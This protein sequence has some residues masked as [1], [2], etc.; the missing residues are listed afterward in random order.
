MK[1]MLT[2][3]YSILWQQVIGLS[4]VQGAISLCWLLY[5]LYLPELLADFGLPGLAPAILIIENVLGI[6]IEP[7]AGNFSDRQRQWMGTRF[8][9]I[10]LG[11]ILATGLFIA[12]PTFVIFGQSL[13]NSGWILP[14]LLILW[15]VSMALFRSPVIA[16][17]GQYAIETKLPQAV[18]LLIFFGGIIGAFRP[19]A[20]EFI[21]SL[22]AGVTFTIGSLV[23]LGSVAILRS[24][25]PNLS[26]TPS[27]S[28]SEK[29][30]LIS[31]LFL[32]VL[33]SIF[34]A[35]GTRL[36]LGDVF[37]KLIINI[38]FDSKLGMFIGLILLAFASIPAGLL[39]VRVGNLKA[40]ASGALATGFLVFVVSFVPPLFFFPLI[41]L[42]LFC[43]S[44][45][46]N[47]VIPIAFSLVPPHRSGLGIGVYFGG[48]SLGMVIY[49]LIVNHF[50][51]V[52]FRFGSSLGMMC[53]VLVGGLIVGI[54]KWISEPSR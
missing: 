36:F 39:A 14:I 38:G 52:P 41:L 18:S 1:V 2:R 33:L 50:G 35:W 13:R 15:S 27:S 8:P 6:V 5:R 28:L 9:L 7:V 42:L 17:L 11:V 16:L 46:V 47:G 40:T 43:Y 30:G 54:G 26:V 25:N 34:V 49:D 21:L 19:I 10:S 32:I 37:P 3:Q 29:K 4:F 45:V 53:F 31:N 22:G 51:Q 44:L 48:F 24:L 23:L 12:I 20:S